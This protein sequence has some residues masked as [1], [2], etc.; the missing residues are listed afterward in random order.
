[1]QVASQG[2]PIAMESD[3]EA[4]LAEAAAA[5]EALGASSDDVLGMPQ[6][7]LPGMMMGDGAT[8]N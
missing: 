5:A 7:Q 2:E 8:T 4:M 1:M 6:V 3:E